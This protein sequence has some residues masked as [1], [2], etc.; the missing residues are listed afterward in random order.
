MMLSKPGRLALLID[1]VGWVDNDFFTKNMRALQGAVYLLQRLGLQFG[2]KF[3]R[4]TYMYS[5]ELA[6]DFHSLIHNGDYFWIEA[7]EHDFKLEA[8]KIILDS[9]PWIKPPQK[10]TTP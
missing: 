7:R 6:D 2:Y 4:Y 9:K 8:E 10:E 1:A 5:S 3:K